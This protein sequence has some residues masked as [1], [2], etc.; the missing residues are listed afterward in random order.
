MSDTVRQ[1]AEAVLAEV[2]EISKVVLPEPVEAN[3][4]VPLEK[5]ETGVVTLFEILSCNSSVS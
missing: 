5:A 1:K 2:E 4:I 3:A